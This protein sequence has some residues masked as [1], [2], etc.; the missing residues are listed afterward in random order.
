MCLLIS[1]IAIAQVGIGTTNPDA[2]SILDITSTNK[3]LLAPRMTTAQKNAIVSPATS[4]MVF[5]TDLGK[6]SYYNGITWIT[7]EFATVR[8]QYTLV[9]SLADLPSPSAGVITLNSGW[10]YEI[11]GGISIPY[12]INLNGAEIIGLNH[13]E[14]QL[15]FTG[16]GDF[17][18]GTQGGALERLTIT[19]NSPS[20]KNLFNL[21]DA[22]NTKV[23]KIRDSYIMGWSSVGTI[24]GHFIVYMDLLGFMNNSDG[25]IYDSVDDLFLMKQ[26]WF[27]TNSGTFTKLQGTF[28][29]IT[30]NGGLFEVSSGSIGL[31]VSSTPIINTTAHASGGITFS[32]TGTY[33]FPVANATT[34]SFTKKWEVEGAG[35]IT[36]KDEVA[37]GSIYIN[38]P[39]T[40]IITAKNVPTKVNGT[41]TA[42]NLFR[43][44][45]NGQSNRLRY[46]GTEKRY[47]QINV[48]FSL[49]GGKND[50]YAFYIYKNGVRVPSIYV[51]NKISNADVGA[52][53]LVGTV[54]LSTNDYIELWTED[55]NDYGNCEINAMNF[56][57][58]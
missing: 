21:T 40:T 30:I 53:S 6:F 7:L 16:T 1:K 2:S 56:V 35:I 50:I 15:I 14:D 25:I 54:E 3:G 45:T 41:T 48:T 18:T 9:K 33:V 4:L 52:A 58:K 51:Q 26:L 12:K 11:N 46:T 42:T 27:D 19:T 57:I 28:D 17:L 29:D 5:D 24:S 23:L 10:V 31:D 22:T 47:F 38:S 8:D 43:F 39:A 13:E 37:T 34:P 32:G 49:Q 20:G 55:L 36:E 44:D